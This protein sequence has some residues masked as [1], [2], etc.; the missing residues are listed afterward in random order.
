[1]QITPKADPVLGQIYILKMYL[2]LYP[3]KVKVIFILSSNFAKTKP[4]L[5]FV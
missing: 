3:G 2:F 1:M 5:G 4:N